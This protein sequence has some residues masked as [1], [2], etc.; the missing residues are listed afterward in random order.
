[1]DEHQIPSLIAKD[2]RSD[3]KP[4][5]CPGCG[6]FAVLSALTK[7]LAY[8]GLAQQNVAIIS[9]IG[10][11]SRLPAYIASYGF[12][13]VHGRALALASGLKAARPDLTVIVAGGDGDGFSIGGNHFLHACRRN[14]DLTYVVM[15]NE[16][17]GMTKGQASPTTQPE[18]DHSK[19]TPHGTG[20]RRFQPA[21]IALAAGASFIARGFSGDPN[22]LVHLLTRAIEHP[23]FAFLQVLSPC[24]TFRPEQ[25]AWKHMVHPCRLAPTHDAARA[26]ELIQRDDGM[27]LGMLYSQTLPVFANPPVDRV[28]LDQIEAEFCL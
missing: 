22:G 25:Q 16:V 9:G 21:A 24:Q 28:G 17:Y 11:S 27:A 26:A 20:I 7:T 15:D 1:M 19:L 10:C 2:Y 5:W 13:G 4:V 18:W 14:M 8:L 23:G 3:I 6:H 12:H